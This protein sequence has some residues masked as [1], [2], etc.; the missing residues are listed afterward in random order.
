MAT[1]TAN[2]IEM[3]YAQ[4]GEGPHLVL[5][6][7]LGAHAGAWALNAPAFAKHF[8]VT[9]FDNRGAGR[10]EAPD[11]PYSMGQMGDDT[12]AL[13]DALGI[14]SAHVLGASMGG[15]VA[16]ELAIRHPEKVERLVIA[17]SRART[18]ELRRTVA[19]AQRALWEAGIP[20]ESIRA[21]QSPWGSTSAVL[22]D[23]G[24]TLQNLALAAKDPHPIAKHA[25]LRQLDAVLAHDT[26]DRLHRITAETLVLVGAEDILTPPS[27][28]EELAR[29]IPNARM[30]I[31]PRGGHGFS[32]EYAPQ[33][34]AAALAFLR[35]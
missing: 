26:L 2:G 5:I 28:S 30:Q 20:A 24:L 4:S 17:C 35:G 8:R 27:E 25:Y 33:F 15:M 12:A 6:M 3:Y 19:V 23:E 7:G 18:G 29:H 21:I 16:Q 34:N 32:G 13:M 31:L 9:V 22:Q 14:A 1:I 11:E 10:T